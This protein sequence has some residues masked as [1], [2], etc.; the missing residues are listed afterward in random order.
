MKGDLIK[1]YSGSGDAMAENYAGWTRYNTV[2]YQ[3]GTHGGRYVNNYGNAKA[4]SYSEYED[5]GRL[6][7]GAIIAKDSFA[8]SSGGKVSPGPLFTMEKMKSGF[9][10]ESGDW[11]YSL[12]MP[13]GKVMGTTNGDGSNMVEFCIGCH[14]AVGESQDHLF[15][16][17]EQYRAAKD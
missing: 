14:A 5:A 7:V 11:R 15:F 1:G 6:P 3:S 16:L 13:N 9:R 12:I 8:V 10:E 17:P 2:P 4:A